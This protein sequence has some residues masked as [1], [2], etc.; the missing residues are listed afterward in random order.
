MTRLP[1]LLPTLHQAC[2]CV[3][4]IE[5][6]RTTLVKRCAAHARENT[7]AISAELTDEEEAK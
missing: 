7:R 3:W 4:E 1:P 6:N 5:R 2:G